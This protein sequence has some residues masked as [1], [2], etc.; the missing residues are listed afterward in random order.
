MC[1]AAVWLRGVIKPAPG[2]GVAYVDWAQQEF[3]VAAALSGDLAM[4]AAYETGDP[5]LAFAVQAG[6]APVGASRPTHALV[7]E[8]FKAT[9]LAVQYAMGETGLALRLEQPPLVARHLLQLH[10]ETYNVYL[11]SSDRALT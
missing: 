5:Y 4:L 1:G 6:A 7:R 11:K 3:G 2:H 9:V 8:Q 10:H